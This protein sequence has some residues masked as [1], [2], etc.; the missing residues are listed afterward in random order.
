MTTPVQAL[1][2]NWDRLLSGFEGEERNRVADALRRLRDNLV[3]LEWRYQEC[4]SA[5]TLPYQPAAPGYT[6]PSVNTLQL[7]FVDKV[8]AFHQH[9]YATLAVLALVLNH[10]GKRATKQPYPVGSISKFLSALRERDFRY[11]ERYLGHVAVL[12]KSADFRSKYVDHPER[13]QLHDWMTYRFMD[14]AYVI[15]FIKH[16]HVVRWA[17]ASPDPLSPDF[18]PPVDCG[19]DFYVS[20]NIELTCEAMR[21][22]SWRRYM[23]REGAALPLG[24]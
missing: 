18:R 5:S 8:E 16:G 7:R 12:E 22:V 9:V 19:E 23:S 1:D 24:M 4:R 13:H 2:R 6:G 11:K 15:Y 21:R 14:T 20:P 3:R 17:G 10:L